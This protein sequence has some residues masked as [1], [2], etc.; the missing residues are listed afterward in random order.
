MITIGIDPGTVRTGYGVVRRDGNRFTNLNSGTIQTD[1]KDPLES[2]LLSIYDGI[3]GVLVRHGPDE[4]AV[5]ALFFSRHPMSALK[6]GH[7]RGVIVLALA[8]HT[9]P[10]HSYPP[11]TIKRFIAGTGRATKRQMQKVVQ[12]ILGMPEL[13]LED[14][15]D[16][17][18]V[19]I[20]HLNASRIQSNRRQL[21]RIA[22]SRSRR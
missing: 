12:A 18:A 13:P 15:S 2:R 17:L 10:I 8:R 11:A 6:L 1:E 7:A 3:E 4:A 9:V 16:A 14:E 19:A 22:D 20:C 5:E 21:F